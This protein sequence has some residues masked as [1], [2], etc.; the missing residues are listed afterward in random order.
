MLPVRLQ[1]IL[2]STST[3]PTAVYLS[4]DVPLCE[5]PTFPTVCDF[6]CSD[7]D[8]A[9]VL[10]KFP[11]TLP[12]PPGML[13]SEDCAM[14]VSPLTPPPLSLCSW[15]SFAVLNASADLFNR[16][17]SSHSLV[18]GE[19]HCCHSRCSRCG[20]VGRRVDY[21]YHSRQRKYI[22]GFASLNCRDTSKGRTVE[23]SA[24][25]PSTQK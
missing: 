4:S 16:T 17:S 25:S 8:T 15:W 21:Q 20:K 22:A 5:L 19:R 24:D 13:E 3:Y 14:S 12:E 6:S 9:G 7:A 2:G 11:L 1:A 10:S 18:P 23:M